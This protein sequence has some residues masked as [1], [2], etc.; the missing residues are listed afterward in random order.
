MTARR[1]L[2]VDL[3]PSALTSQAFLAVTA[4]CLDHWHA[5][6][7]GVVSDRE[8]ESLHQMRVGLRRFRSALS[9]FARA[10]EDPQVT[11]LS[12]EIRELTL[13]LGVA[14]DLDIFLERVTAP[15]QVTG[16]DTDPDPGV[17]TVAPSV[18]ADL[19]GRRERAYDEVAQVVASTRW[20]DAW[21]LVERFRRHAPWGLAPDPP[22]RHTA[23][24][25][26]ERR[27]RRIVHK[28]VDLATMSAVERHRLRIQA[29]KLRYGAQFFDQLFPD[30]AGTPP[31]TFASV[32][33]DLQD[34]LGV[35]NDV[36]TEQLLRDSV[37][38]PPMSVAEAPLI[39]EA[40]RVHQQVRDLTPF[41]S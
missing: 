38:L 27:W 29:K 39:A 18:L 25:A 8:V 1:A 40:V 37:G 21:R 35:L 3:D 5:N 31:L 10:L 11:W 7:P 30:P 24:A 9:L 41:W 19:W 20:A 4:E 32:M 14:R 23:S 12:D 34:A 36:H 28:R 17:E 16:P 22:A 33:G 13:P 15:Q 26:L 2:G 6:V